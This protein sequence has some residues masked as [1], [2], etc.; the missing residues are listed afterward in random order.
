MSKSR[1][2]AGGSEQPES[3]VDP[4]QANN[5]SGKDLPTP[6]SGDDPERTAGIVN[7]AH[8][9]KIDRQKGRQTT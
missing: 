5:H 4:D 8:D 7:P 2:I 9:E 3:L 1:D 6:V